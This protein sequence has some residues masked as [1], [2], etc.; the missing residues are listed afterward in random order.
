MRLFLLILLLVMQSAASAAAVY[1]EIFNTMPEDGAKDVAI[2]GLLKIYFNQ[3][4]N[5]VTMV[6]AAFTLSDQYGTDLKTSVIYDD[7]RKCA[8]IKPDEVLDWNTSYTLVVAGYLLKNQLGYPLKEN[9]RICFKTLSE[10]KQENSRELDKGIKPKI[11]MTSPLPNGRDFP[12]NGEIVFTFNK[13]MLPSSLNKFTVLLFATEDLKPVSGAFRYLPNVK[14]LYFKPEKLE[15][16][17]EYQLEIREGIRDLQDN[18]LSNPNKFKFRIIDT[19]PPVV[20]YVSPADKAEGVSQYARIALRFSEELDPDALS[21]KNIEL[22]SGKDIVPVQA[23]YDNRLRSL[24]LK[25]EKALEP[26]KYLLC[27]KKIRDLS[28]NAISDYSISFEVIPE[29]DTTPPDIVR[30]DPQEGS[31]NIPVDCQVK[32]W[33]S[34][35]LKADS[36]CGLNFTMIEKKS[37]NIIKTKLNFILKDKLVQ[38]IPAEAL[39]YTS[40]ILIKVSRNVSDLEGNRMIDHSFS[41]RTASPPDTAPPFVSKKNFGEKSPV[42]VFFQLEFSEPLKTG[43][44]TNSTIVLR[45]AGGRKITGEVSLKV[46]LVLYYKP[47][48]DLLFEKDYE[49]IVFRDDISDETGNHPLENIVFKVRTMDRPDK[50]P[51]RLVECVP[52]EGAKDVQVSSVMTMRFDEPLLNESVN[53]YSILLYRDG[54]TILGDVD[55]DR[56][57]N[58]VSF[59]PR[60]LL[61][62]GTHYS[63]TAVEA[64][65][66][67]CQNHLPKPVTLN[68][69]TEGAPDDTPPRVLYSSPLAGAVNVK[70]NSLITVVFSEPVKAETLTKESVRINAGN[71]QIP[72]KLDY[73]PLISKLLLTPAE[74]L[75]YNQNYQVTIGSTVSD[76]AGNRMSAEKLIPFKIEA[77]PDLDPPEILKTAPGDQEEGVK[78]DAACKVV[79][80]EALDDHTVNEYTVVLED[81]NSAAK[82]NGAVRY[83]RE[84]NSLE[85]VPD[86]PLPPEHKYTLNLSPD[87][88]DRIGNKLGTQYKL[89]FTSE[90]APDAVRPEIVRCTPE[91]KAQDVDLSAGFKVEFSE[92]VNEKTLND[93]TVTLIDDETGQKFPLNLKYNKL[94]N[95]LTCSSKEKLEYYRQYRLAL[96][97][98]IE[99]LAGN[100]LAS[101]RIINF[102]TVHAPD[103]IPPVVKYCDPADGTTEASV[104]CKIAIVFSERLE[105]KSVNKTNLILK[106]GEAELETSL[107]YESEFAKVTLTPVKTLDFACDYYVYATTG[108]RDQAG[109]SIAKNQVLKFRTAPKPDTVKPEV[110]KSSPDPGDLQ[111]SITPVISIFF[112]EDIDTCSV[113]SNSV[114]LTDGSDYI[115]GN[116]KYNQKRHLLEYAPV[117]K[118]EYNRTYHFLLTDAIRDLAGNPLVRTYIVEFTTIMP[119][120]TEP[121]TLVNY[122]PLPNSIDNK[123]HPEI[124]LFFSEQL[125]EDSING[126]TVIVKNRDQLI[127]VQ[128]SYSSMERAVVANLKNELKTGEKYS[129]TVTDGIT[130]LAGNGLANPKTFLFYVGHPTDIAAPKTVILSPENDAQNISE[131]A[132]ICAAFSTGIDPTT[133][134]KYTFIVRDNSRNITGKIIYNKALNRAEFYPDS[135][136]AKGRQYQ[137]VLTKGIRGV[138]GVPLDDTVTWNF[139]VADYK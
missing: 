80:S 60:T 137:A 8:L 44:I 99:D 87:I 18:L 48:N 98:T 73:N 27:L 131:K 17:R 26:G 82:V 54:E 32:I 64:V 1:P 122:T 105:D 12:L 136:L 42:D 62:Y 71:H 123:V 76:L 114:T 89:R 103:R 21:P 29:R 102:R 115:P 41:F 63:L 107:A 129:V 108:I 81:Q 35:T 30:T 59:K 14:K 70:V 4:M 101:T 34:E 100:C 68:F 72:V 92:A 66:D 130:D 45:D 13:E 15:E 106:K 127:P 31:A 69:Q 58:E 132:V 128:L 118:L 33:F 133:L 24:E 10:V 6:S 120:D 3:H 19:V 111:V 119:P 40:E 36:V 23:V 37:S 39:P 56:Q 117:N 94:G 5:D 2:D 91:D 28:G 110:V 86:K 11:I 88:S 93:F 43:L 121:P 78:C 77:Q 104:D 95:F 138:N 113:T 7:E 46:P 22:K 25:P 38:I 112:S 47:L 125:K 109:N 79:F 52:K 16:G 55:Y 57:K 50:N 49:L 20:T 124:K 90:K 126:Y 96:S 139:T 61:N 83:L 67:C 75:D 65:S 84:E 74:N 135:G 116:T 51:P 134:N 53:I 97:R 9:Y 85:F